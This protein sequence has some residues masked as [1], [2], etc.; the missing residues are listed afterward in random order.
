[1][2]GDV[3]IDAAQRQLP[4]LRGGDGLHDEL[5]IGVRRLRLILR[6]RDSTG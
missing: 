5:G 4:I 6:E 2:L 1:M 3:G